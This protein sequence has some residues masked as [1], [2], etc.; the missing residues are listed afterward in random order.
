MAD[1]VIAADTESWLLIPAVE[2][3]GEPY[4]IGV[5]GKAAI[6][7][8]TVALVNEYLA[9][10]DRS[11][12]GYTGAGGN[13]T[14]S[15]KDDAK[16]AATSSETDGDKPINASGNFIVPTSQNY[17]A[18]F[19]L[20]R[21]KDSASTSSNY[22][23]ANDNVRAKGIR[24]IAFRRIGLGWNVAA[25]SGQKYS[26]FYVETDNPIDQY[27]DGVNQ[28]IGV[29]FITKSIAKIDASIV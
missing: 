17:E 24:Y 15:V 26:A 9:I 2:V 5:A 10:V 8:L 6:G 25:V 14:P 27:G 23:L 16:L 29:N 13:I 12:A 3:L 20:F 4:G 19:T 21:D 1:K 28:S 7:A 22:N 18:Q 11:S